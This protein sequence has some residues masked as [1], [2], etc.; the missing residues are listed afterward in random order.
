MFSYKLGATGLNG[1][2]AKLSKMETETVTFKDNHRPEF[3]PTFE[4]V[5]IKLIYEKATRILKG[6]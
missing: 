4:E 1:D 5:I 3:M 2:C 6:A